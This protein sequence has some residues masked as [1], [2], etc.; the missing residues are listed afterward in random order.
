MATS[1]QSR[2]KQAS[3]SKPET[4]PATK[5]SSPEVVAKNFKSMMN[6]AY[7]MRID[8]EPVREGGLNCIGGWKASLKTDKETIEFDEAALAE[9]RYEKGDYLLDDT[10]GKGRTVAFYTMRKVSPR[11]V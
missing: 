3:Q 11:L 5:T 1:T 7:E 9:V 4:R 2:Q 6:K 10:G 8:D